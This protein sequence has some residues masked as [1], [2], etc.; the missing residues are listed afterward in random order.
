M[1]ILGHTNTNMSTGRYGARYP[2]DKLLDAISKLD[3]DLD[4][5]ALVSSVEPQGILIG[6]SRT[7]CLSQ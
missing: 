5:G 2:V 4:F 6:K 3:Y 7:V 1:Q